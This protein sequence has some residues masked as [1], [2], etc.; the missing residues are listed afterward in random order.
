[1]KTRVCLNYFVNDCSLPNEISINKQEIIITKNKF[2]I[3]AHSP[4]LTL[5]K[6]LRACPKSSS[7]PNKNSLL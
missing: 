7:F 2:L 6:K 3:L 4:S 1:M 5:R